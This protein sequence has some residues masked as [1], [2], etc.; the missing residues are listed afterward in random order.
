MIPQPIVS[1]SV[2]SRDQRRDD[3]RGARLHP[4]LAPPRVGLGEPDR[5]HA[6]LVHRPRRRDHLVERLHRQLHDPDPERRRH[7]ASS[8]PQSPALRGPARRARSGRARPA[9]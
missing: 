5:V 4:V 1:R 6:R 9:G 8:R 7:G 2:V 3:G